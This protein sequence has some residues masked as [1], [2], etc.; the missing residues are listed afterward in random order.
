MGSQRVGHDWVTELSWILIAVIFYY[1]EIICFIKWFYFTCNKDLSEVKLSDIT[2]KNM[3]YWSIIGRFQNWKKISKNM[4]LELECVYML[5]CFSPVGLFETSW[6]VACPVP[7][8]WDTSGKNIGVCCHALLH[9]IFPAQVS[10][11]HHLH[12]LHWEMSSLPL[13][14]PECKSWIHYFY[15]CILA[16]ITDLWDP[17]PLNVNVK[18]G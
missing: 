1:E 16:W 9:G 12:L 6:T 2:V 10:N 4:H 7:L 15:L 17:L 18:Y 13:V 8:S 3:S 5:S 11:P 14:A